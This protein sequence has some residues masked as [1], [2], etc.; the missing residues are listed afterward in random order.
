[1]A[2]QKSQVCLKFRFEVANSG[3]RNAECDEC[4]MQNAKCGVEN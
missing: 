3:F 1:M 4:G 2:R